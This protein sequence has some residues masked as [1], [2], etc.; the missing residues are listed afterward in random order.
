[1]PSKPREAN[2][3]ALIALIFKDQAKGDGKMDAWN[4]NLPTPCKGGQCPPES[5]VLGSCF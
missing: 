2:F 5:A 1:M 4:L 3:S